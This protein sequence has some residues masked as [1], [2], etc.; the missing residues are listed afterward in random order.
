MEP[1][2]T[3]YYSVNYFYFYFFFISDLFLNYISLK[4]ATEMNIHK[5]QKTNAG[6]REPS[7]VWNKVEIVVKNVICKDCGESIHKLGKLHVE[8][9]RL[10]RNVRLELS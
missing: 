10:I 1:F 3:N 6:G 4:M 9:V 8:R 7:E 5:K 2:R